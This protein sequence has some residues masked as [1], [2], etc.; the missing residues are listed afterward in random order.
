MGC[1]QAP[2][3]IIKYPKQEETS[4]ASLTGSRITLLLKEAF[5][6][7]LATAQPLR[8]HCRPNLFLFPNGFSFRTAPLS[9]S[10]FLKMQLPP[11]LFRFAYGLP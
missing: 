10:F 4:L 7:H 3:H 11:L 6:S 9:P 2:S 8:S 1:T 5:S